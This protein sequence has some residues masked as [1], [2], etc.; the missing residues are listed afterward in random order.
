[1]TFQFGNA[2]IH[3]SVSPTT[4]LLTNTCLQ[5]IPKKLRFYLP[6]WNSMKAARPAQGGPNS[7]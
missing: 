6:H 4:H 1:L 3:Y 5:H 2:A 7:A